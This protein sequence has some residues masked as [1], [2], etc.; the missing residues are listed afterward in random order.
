MNEH[1]Y[2]IFTKRFLSDDNIRALTPEQRFDL[3]SECDTEPADE[4]VCDACAAYL[5]AQEMGDG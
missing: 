1:C 3:M 5:I 4:S 2:G